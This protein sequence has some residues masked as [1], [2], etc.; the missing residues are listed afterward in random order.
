MF[1]KNRKVSALQ[2]KR[3]LILDIVTFG[4]MI[5]PQT[6]TGWSGRAAL[7]GGGLGLVGLFVYTGFFLCMSDGCVGSYEDFMATA[8][9]PFF[10]GVFICLYLIK[11][12]LTLVVGLGLFGQVLKDT[13]LTEFPEPLLIVL[14]ALVLLYGCTRGME[15]RGRMAEVCSY[16]VLVPVI[17]ILI[18]ALP[19]VKFEGLVPMMTIEEGD[20]NIFHSA[21]FWLIIGGSVELLLF[22][23]GHMAKEGKGLKSKVC[24]S[25]GFSGVL[26][27]VI[28]AVVIGVF[29]VNGT[30]MTPWP[31]VRLTQMVRIPGSFLA[32]QDGLVL[33]FW[34]FGVYIWMSGYL[35]QL[36]TLT[37]KVIKDKRRGLIGFCWLVAGVFILSI[38][39][40]WQMLWNGYVW[41]MEMIG[42]PQSLILPLVVSFVYQLRRLLQR[43]KK[44]A[45]IKKET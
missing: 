13:L 22:T 16:V 26:L 33:C 32:R 29:G 12:L 31:A 9:G 44:D 10:S 25:I 11:Y 37:A 36:T 34:I 21:I 8:L 4:L 19:Q 39:G 40:S 2:V 15:V 30:T 7:V 38:I 35:Y 42:I 18:L 5:I 3:L 28:T 20:M 45:P 41:Y 23:G 17:L 1:S 27:L 14:M 43:R 6:M 24:Q